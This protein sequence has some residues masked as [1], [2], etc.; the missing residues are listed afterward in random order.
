MKRRHRPWA[1]RSVGARQ[2]L[3]LFIWMGGGLILAP[4]VLYVS[5]WFLLLI[6]ALMAAVA[7]TGFSLRCPRCHADVWKLNPDLTMSRRRAWLPRECPKCGLSTTSEWPQSI[8]GP[9]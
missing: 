2:G 9:A 6:L 5:P 7:T 8:H 1:Q 4:L 3:L